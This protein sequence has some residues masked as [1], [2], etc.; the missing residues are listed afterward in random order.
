MSR[1]HCSLSGGWLPPSLQGQEHCASYWV[2]GVVDGGGVG[3]SS[4]MWDDLMCSWIYGKS[5]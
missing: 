2:S 5:G 4:G 3:E 1:G